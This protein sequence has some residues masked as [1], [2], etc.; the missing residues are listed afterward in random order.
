MKYAKAILGSIAVFVLLDFLISV[1]IPDRV[2][3]AI[4]VVVSA[5]VL[6]GMLGGFATSRDLPR[7]LPSGRAR[8]LLWGIRLKSNRMFRLI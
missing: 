2:M 7:L 1:L 5:L 4:F 8:F 3:N 6:L